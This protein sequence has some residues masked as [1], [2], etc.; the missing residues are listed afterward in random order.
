MNE[1]VKSLDGIWQRIQRLLTTIETKSELS[2]SQSYVVNGISTKLTVTG[3]KSPKQLED[4][5]FHIF[6]CLWSVKD[7]FK[8]VYEELD[9]DP[10]AIEQLVDKHFSLQLISDI[11]NRSKHGN[12]RPKPSRSK[13]NTVL[14]KV[15][16][17]IPQRA[18]SQISVEANKIITNVNS[19]QEVILRARIEDKDGQDICDAF[20]VIWSSLDIWEAEIAK[21]NLLS[22]T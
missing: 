17:D 13:R 9:Q 5:L 15:G 8:A 11:A 14:T 18:I 20:E 22:E 21:I 16:I 7:Y 2:F 1:E 4:E 3:I 12:Y 19:S 10:K 6:E